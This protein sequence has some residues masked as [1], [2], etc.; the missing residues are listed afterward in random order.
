MRAATTPQPA[1]RDLGDE[2]S[3][4]QEH[5]GPAQPLTAVSAPYPFV[6]D[7][8]PIFDED[9]VSEGVSWRPG[10][11]TNVI[12]TYYEERVRLEADGVGE[13]LLTEVS[14]HKPGRYP[15]R[16][17]FT[18]QWRDP[19]GRIF[20]KTKLRMTTA[21]AFDRLKRGY[22]YPYDMADPHPTK[23]REDG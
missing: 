17:F 20:G 11:R 6:R 12:A 1:G 7:A 8:C 4:A 3:P 19:D 2:P 10:T 22:A 16:V 23:D 13:I 9:G 5:R 15:E 18:R 21:H 14:R